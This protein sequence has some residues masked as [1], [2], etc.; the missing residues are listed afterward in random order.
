MLNRD[1]SGPLWAVCAYF[2]PLRWRRRLANF[3]E[4]RRRL[5]VPLLA[6]ELGYA[7]QFALRSDD[8]ELLLQLPGRDVMWQKERLLNLGLKALPPTCEAVAWLDADLVFGSD[9]WADR[10]FRELERSVLVQ[11]FHEIVDLTRD[12]ANSD[13]GRRPAGRTGLAF[14]IASGRLAPGDVCTVMPAW[15]PGHG[16]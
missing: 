16:W 1:P 4:V 13:I 9:D 14:E 6:V 8:A 15:S 5:S 10:A 7:P 12:D 11:P 2:N 3:Q